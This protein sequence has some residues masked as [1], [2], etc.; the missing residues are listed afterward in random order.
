MGMVTVQVWD[1]TGNKR[2]DVELPDGQT[3]TFSGQ[4]HRSV[5]YDRGGRYG[6]TQQDLTAGT[7]DFRVTATGWDLVRQ[8]DAPALSRTPVRANSLPAQR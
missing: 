4:P 6:S 8:P 3:Q 5:Q 2:Q 7:Y 1:A